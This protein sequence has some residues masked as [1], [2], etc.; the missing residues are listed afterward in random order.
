MNACLINT[1]INILSCVPLGT[2]V[3]LG[4]KCYTYTQVLHLGASLFVLLFYV[5]FY[6]TIHFVFFVL[7]CEAHL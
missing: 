6:L 3:A 7:M 1:F 4:F 5:S 2:S